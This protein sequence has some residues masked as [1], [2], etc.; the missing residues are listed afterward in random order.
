MLISR[1]C[2]SHMLFFSRCW[3]SGLNI[4]T[5]VTGSRRRTNQITSQQLSPSCSTHRVSHLSFTSLF[6]LF[7][8][9]FSFHI[10]FTSLLHL[11]H[12]SI[13]QLYFTL[14]HLSFTSFTSFFKSVSHLR[15]FFLSLVFVFVLIL[16]YSVR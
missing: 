10:S 5:Q 12:S 4:T 13:S 15:F 2:Y 6:H 7:L 14:F 3:K 8:S 11:F 9:H 1:C 16:L